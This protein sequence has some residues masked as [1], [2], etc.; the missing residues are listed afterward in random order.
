M[1]IDSP[2]LSTENLV[3]STSRKDNIRQNL[4]HFFGR[5]VNICP[6]FAQCLTGEQQES[7]GRPTSERFSSSVILQDLNAYAKD[8]N[9]NP[10]YSKEAYY[11]KREEVLITN[12][13]QAST[14]VLKAPVHSPTSNEYAGLL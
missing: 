7:N 2:A 3:P 8:Q 11:S 1:Y 12:G 5:V 14:M 9:T 13:F 6:C 4:A 10:Y